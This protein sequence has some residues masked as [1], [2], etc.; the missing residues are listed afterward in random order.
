MG[1]RRQRIRVLLNHSDMTVLTWLT[2]EYP[3][4]NAES[5]PEVTSR[6]LGVWGHFM[7]FLDGPRACIAHRFSLAEMKPMLFTLIRAFEFGD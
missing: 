1:S 7:T 4:R 6:S 3:D 5:V 2:S